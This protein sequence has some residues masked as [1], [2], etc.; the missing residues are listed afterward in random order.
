M[1]ETDNIAAVVASIAEAFPGHE[2][3]VLAGLV[4]HS[5]AHFLT[6]QPGADSLAAALNQRLAALPGERVWQLG[7]IPRAALD[8]I[9]RAIAEVLASQT[10]H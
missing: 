9:Q 6:E 3:E 1:A 4:I 8:N 5:L 7:L 10:Q 2:N